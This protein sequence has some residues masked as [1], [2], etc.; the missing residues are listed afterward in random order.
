MYTATTAQHQPGGYRLAVGTLQLHDEQ[1]H[2]KLTGLSCTRGA[3]IRR[4][5]A[6]SARQRELIRLRGHAGAGL[7]HGPPGLRCQAPAKFT[8]CLD[9]AQRVLVPDAGKA[10]DGR[11]VV[12]RAEETV[13]RQVQATVGARVEIQP[14]G[15]GPTMALKDRG[16]GRG[17]GAVRRNA[18]W[19]SWWGW[20]YFAI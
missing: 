18:C 15:R 16:A 17:P 4:E 11:Y 8:C 13:G 14:I 2:S 19:R 20:T 9:V 7:V 6:G 10:D 12:E 3:W 5:G 1:R